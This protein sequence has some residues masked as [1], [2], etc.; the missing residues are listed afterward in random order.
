MHQFVGA[1]GHASTDLVSM[2]RPLIQEFGLTN[3]LEIDTMADDRLKNYLQSSSKLMRRIH[4]YKERLKDKSV[5]FAA[6]VADVEQNHANDLI[7][8]DTLK[9][10]T[11]QRATAILRQPYVER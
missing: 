11:K 10:K 5:D 2:I 8:G 9:R 6:V 3:W 7:V 4:K 1:K